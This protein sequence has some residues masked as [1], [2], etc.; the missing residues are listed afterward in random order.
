MIYSLNQQGAAELI[1]PCWGVS[2]LT[3]TPNASHLSSLDDAQI[4]GA[5][6][7]N[8][9]LCHRSSNRYREEQTR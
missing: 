9:P 7:E 8:I 5:K 3:L 2:F 4:K 6:A 1:T